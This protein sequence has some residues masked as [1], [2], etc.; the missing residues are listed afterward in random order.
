MDA[1]SFVVDCVWNKAPGATKA[2]AVLAKT[3]ERAIESFM[4]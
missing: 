3:T 2:V 1:S 4:V